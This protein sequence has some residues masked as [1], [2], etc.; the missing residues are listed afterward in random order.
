[1]PPFRGKVLWVD[2]STG[3]I[4]E[5]EV[6]E[7]V[8]QQVFGGYGLAAKFLFEN[9][10]PKIDPLGERNILC[11][12]SGLLNGTGAWFSGRYMVAAKSPVTGGF[13]MANAG[14]SFGP[15]LKRAGYDAIF[16]VGKSEKPVYLYVEDGKA[17]LR[18]ASHL[19]GKD[20]YETDQIIKTE[21]NNPRVKV[22][23]IG[24]AGEN[25]SMISGIVS[26]RHRIA[27]RTGMG[28]VMGSKKLKAVAV[29]GTGKIEVA[30]REKIMQLNKEF[31]EWYRSPFAKLAAEDRLKSRW[32]RMTSILGRLTL[33][34]KFMVRLQ[35]IFFQLIMM[36]YGTPG[37]AGWSMTSQ[38]SAIKN[39]AGSQADFSTK[40]AMELSDEKILELRT[41]RHACESCPLGCTSLVAKGGRFQLEEVKV[42]YECLASFGSNCLNSDLDTVLKAIDMCNRAG[43]DGISAG[44]VVAFACECYEK[45]LLKAEDIGFPLNWGDGEAHLMLLDKIIK[46]EGIGDLLADGVKRASEKI[47]G[48][49]EFAVH[50]GGV[51]LAM[52]DPRQDPGYGI[53]Y[54]SEPVPG[55]HLHSMTFIDLE[56]LHKIF[57]VEPAP[58]FYPKS[59][60]FSNWEF[61]GKRAAHASVYFHAMSAAGFCLFGP[62][63]A[64][65]RL[66]VL[67]YINA[68]TGWDLGIVDF[69]R[70][71]QRILT[72]MQAFNYREGIRPEDFRVSKRA[73]QGCNLVEAQYAFYEELGWDP[74]CGI[75][76]EEKLRELDLEEV[77]KQLYRK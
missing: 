69:H 11:F 42:E 31:L 10:K 14:G 47:P 23:C 62:L 52:H 7:K 74:V 34:S 24:Q 15:E 13:G 22:A 35:P 46:R 28:A 26:E 51:E 21:T 5:R 72:L 60:R 49:K 38:D 37:F 59:W 18:D 76:M 3:K 66:K 40:Q 12:A 33:Q 68:A 43:L 75:P 8:Y 53:S 61:H 65:A 30:S 45:G 29:L 25:L 57:G 27:A 2:L 54:Q 1:M 39:W 73:A 67:D 20:T 6:E 41:K 77:R 9:L 50:A 71:G 70:V 16:F 56:E 17:E 55:K 44:S 19:W 4:K 36:R 63:T 64:G 58:P 48:S 32:G